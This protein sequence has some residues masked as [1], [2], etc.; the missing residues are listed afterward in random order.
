MKQEF[1]A[2]CRGIPF[3]EDA[4]GIQHNSLNH[5]YTGHQLQDGKSP[6][7]KRAYWGAVSY[8]LKIRHYAEAGRY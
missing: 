2:A 3:Q 7:Q 1:S 4:C 8:I 6:V 5:S